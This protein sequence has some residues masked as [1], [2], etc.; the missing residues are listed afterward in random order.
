MVNTQ[1]D[2]DVI[3]V[4]AGPSGSTT[5]YELAKAGMS[6]LMLEKEKFPRYKPCGGGLSLKIERIL[7]INIKDVIESTITG[8]Y[9]TYQQT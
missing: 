3:V 7:S 6:V 2:F 4:G 5:A 9:F 1:K 8:S